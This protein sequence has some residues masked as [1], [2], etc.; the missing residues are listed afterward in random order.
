ML[1]TWQLCRKPSLTPSIRRESLNKVIAKKSDVPKVLYQ[2]TLIESYVVGKNVKE[3]GAQAAGMTA[4]WRE[5]SGKGHSKCESTESWKLVWLLRGFKCPVV[6]WLI[7][8]YV[9]GKSVE[10]KGAQAAGMRAAWRGLSGKGHS[11]VLGTFTRSGQMDPGHGLELSCFACNASHIL[12]S[13]FKLYY[14]L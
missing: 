11:K 5:S 10:E 9:E 13:P 6:K 4:A 7:E 12:V 1:L 3:K 8:S 2:S 14:I